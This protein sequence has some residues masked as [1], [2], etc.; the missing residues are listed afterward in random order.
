MA[1]REKGPCDSQTDCQ[2]VP[3][4]HQ[5]YCYDH[6]RQTCM[7][8]PLLA[9]LLAGLLLASLFCCQILFLNPDGPAYCDYSHI[10]VR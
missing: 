1:G 6:S 3:E 5:C 10:I 4:A 9:L 2:A 8:D 7:G